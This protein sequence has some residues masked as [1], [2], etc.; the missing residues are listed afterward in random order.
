M[1]GGGWGGRRMG[2]AAAAAG[3]TFVI[4]QTIIWRGIGADRGRGPVARPLPQG[5]SQR[6]V[7]VV[8]SVALVVRVVYEE[9]PFVVVASRVAPLHPRAVPH[10]DVVQQQ[11]RLFSLGRDG[12]IGV[13]GEGGVA[14]IRWAVVVGGDVAVLE[15]VYPFG[16]VE[17]VLVAIM[18]QRSVGVL[19]THTAGLL[20]T[21]IN[22]GYYRIEVK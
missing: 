7:Y 15:D 8:R 19:E 6:V 3:L 16:G 12:G 18:G 21:K 14:K 1:P 10:V 22:K 20:W 4:Q 13:V 11:R 9:R 2:W 5:D 17:D